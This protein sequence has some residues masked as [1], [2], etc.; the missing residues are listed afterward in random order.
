ML[1]VLGC[2]LVQNGAPLLPTPIVDH[3][4]LQV[5]LALDSQALCC[6]SGVDEILKQGPREFD[7]AFAVQ[8]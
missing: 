3:H 5:T 4:H 7:I 8:V 2:A 1:S 6:S